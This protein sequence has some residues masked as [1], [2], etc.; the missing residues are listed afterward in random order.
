MIRLL[1]AELRKVW[2]SRFFSSGVFCAARCQPVFAV[3]R[4]G[5][6]SGQCSLLCLSKV[7]TADFRHEHGGYG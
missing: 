4:H 6:Y 3:V 5:P 2:H 7:G 1:S